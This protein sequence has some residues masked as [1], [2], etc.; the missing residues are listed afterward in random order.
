MRSHRALYAVACLVLSAAAFPSASAAA[1]APT[2]SNNWA[3]YVASASGASGSPFSSISGTWQ[4]PRA[5]CRAGHESYSA[6]WVGLGGDSESAR[7]LEQIGADASCTRS[8]R[9]VYSTWFE[10]LPALPVNLSLKVR[11]GQQLV[12]SVTVRDSRVTLRIRNLTTGARFTT[13][14]HASSVDGSSAEWIVEAPSVCLT[15]GKCRTLQL[16][17]FGQATFE[18]ATAT[19]AGHTGPISDPAWSATQLELRQAARGV[20]GGAQARGSGAL[21][22][23]TPSQASASSGAFSVSWHEQLLGAE[24]PPAPTLPGGEV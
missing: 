24:A 1:T 3:G 20:V 2:I 18:S 6:V 17:D 5:N 8:G 16:A 14:R 19:V 9:A 11:P 4:Q 23:A 12:A 22:L 13:T 15:A 21:V 7:S 10:L